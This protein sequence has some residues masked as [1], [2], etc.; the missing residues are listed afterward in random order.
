MRKIENITNPGQPLKE[1]DWAIFPVGKNGFEKKQYH[2]PVAPEPKYSLDISTSVEK[3]RA[4]GTD[5]LTVTLEILKDGNATTDF[6]GQD[7]YILFTKV[8]G[9]QH[10]GLLTIG[11]MNGVC[12]FMFSTDVSSVYTL[13]TE[14]IFPRIE[15]VPRVKK[16]F[17]AY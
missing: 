14:N 6:D 7:H 3:I 16:R 4:N 5:N 11:F 1:G 8:D 15:G 10:G 12:T 2:E 9:T 13:S 17:I